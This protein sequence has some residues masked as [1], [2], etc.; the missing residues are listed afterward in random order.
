MSSVPG[1]GTKNLCVIHCGQKK[2]KTKTK[3]KPKEKAEACEPEINVH[4]R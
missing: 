4:I 3:A 2:K 1:R